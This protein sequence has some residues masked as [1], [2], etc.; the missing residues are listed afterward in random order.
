VALDI[1]VAKGYS[2]AILTSTAGYVWM[3]IYMIAYTAGILLFYSGT[4][5]AEA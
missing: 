4:S 1:Y 5:D 3:L 2:S